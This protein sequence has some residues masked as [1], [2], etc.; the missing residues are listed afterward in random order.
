MSPLEIDQFRKPYSEIS[1]P[2][3]YMTLMFNKLW[4]YLFV[5]ILGV[6]LYYVRPK[7]SKLMKGG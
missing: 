6:I 7:K 3:S 2:F 1:Q 4:I 5:L